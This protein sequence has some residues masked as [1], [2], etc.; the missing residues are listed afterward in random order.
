MLLYKKYKS[1][2]N[3]T[4]FTSKTRLSL[5]VTEAQFVLI[6]TL[7]ATALWAV[8]VSPTCSTT[9]IMRFMHDIS[10]DLLHV[11]LHVEIIS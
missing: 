4:D 5:T 2:S 6:L 11:E 8:P 3:Y 7:H 9:Y 1:L 10:L